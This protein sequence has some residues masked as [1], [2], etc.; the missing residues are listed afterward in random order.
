MGPLPDFALGDPLEVE[1]EQADN[2]VW[3]QFRVYQT[4]PGKMSLVK[5]D[6][7]DW[8]GGY[9]LVGDPLRLPDDIRRLPPSSA[10][11]IE[12]GCVVWAWA[13]ANMKADYR[14]GDEVVELPGP[15]G[16]WRVKEERVQCA[17]RNT[18]YK[19]VYS[20]MKP[21]RTIKTLQSLA[22]ILFEKDHPTLYEQALRAIKGKD[23]T[24]RPPSPITPP[25]PVLTGPADT[26]LAVTSPAPSSNQIAEAKALIA[27]YCRHWATSGLRERQV[28]RKLD[29]M[30]KQEEQRLDAPVEEISRERVS[31]FLR[32]TAYRWLTVGIS[33]SSTVSLIHARTRP[34]VF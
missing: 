16:F 14:L 23:E 12:N 3:K 7:V 31:P 28:D 25:Y 6:E 22:K 30:L 29:R 4:E 2:H 1:V 15:G 5:V 27:R 8:L 17:S 26:P 19:R 18:Y 32:P 33:P 9:E 34:S 24:S 13:H 11:P 20:P 10:P 21:Q